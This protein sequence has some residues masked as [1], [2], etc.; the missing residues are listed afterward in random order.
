MVIPEHAQVQAMA[1]IKR[2]YQKHTLNDESIGW[3]ELSDELG[4]V[5]AEVMGDDAFCFWLDA[6]REKGG[7]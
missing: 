7:E 3:D 5:L 6:M 4:N 2:A 1:A